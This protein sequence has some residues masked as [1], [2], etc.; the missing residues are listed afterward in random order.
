MKIDTERFDSIGHLA[1]VG[2]VLAAGDDLKAQI[3]GVVDEFLLAKHGNE[4]TDLLNVLGGHKNHALLARKVVAVET[5]AHLRSAEAQLQPQPQAGVGSSPL[6]QD[7][8]SATTALDPL[9]RRFTSELEDK[10]QERI[11]AASSEVR[12]CVLLIL[13]SWDQINRATDE[14]QAPGAIAAM[15]AELPEAA[16]SEVT[17]SLQTD[18][19]R[20]ERGEFDR[21]MRAAGELVSLGNKLDTQLTEYELEF[22]STAIPQIVQLWQVLRYVLARGAAQGELPKAAQIAQELSKLCQVSPESED[23]FDW[24]M[25]MID[26]RYGEV[27]H[28]RA[29]ALLLNEKGV[30]PTTIPG[31]IYGERDNPAYREWCK[32]ATTVVAS[33]TTNVLTHIPRAE[34]NPSVYNLHYNEEAESMVATCDRILENYRALTALIESTRRLLQLDPNLAN[35]TKHAQIQAVLKAVEEN[36]KAKDSACVS[37]TDRGRIFRVGDVI[38][39][40]GQQG[41]KKDKKFS[42]RPDDN[43]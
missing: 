26:K 38:V 33:F 16:A 14:L 15:I 4:A 2:Q 27:D 35:F 29:R 41:L 37:G 36:K 21:V 42:Y 3:D 28:T 43:A 12:R 20:I 22:N 6:E 32:E 24:L 31:R 40:R 5:L 7:Y 25:K 10:N 8:V 19:E 34:G 23:P 30:P 9:T 17:K 18:A 11:A 13:N 39:A 1:P